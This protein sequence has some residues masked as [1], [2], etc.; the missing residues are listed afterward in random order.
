MT[1]E[2]S[3]LLDAMI[4]AAIEGAKWGAIFASVYV[5]L[6]ILYD[7]AKY[8]KATHTLLREMYADA[9]AEQVSAGLRDKESE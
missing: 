5:G 2:Q 3:Q 1:D 9:R 6:G 7:L 8:T 4:D